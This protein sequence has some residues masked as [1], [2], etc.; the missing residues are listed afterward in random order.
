MFLFDGH[1]IDFIHFFYY[2]CSIGAKALTENKQ[3]EYAYT[4]SSKKPIFI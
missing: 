4:I 2:L 3:Q 1:L